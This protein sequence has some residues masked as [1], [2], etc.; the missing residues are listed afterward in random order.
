MTEVVD[1]QPHNVEIDQQVYTLEL[2]GGSSGAGFSLGFSSGFGPGQVTDIKQINVALVEAPKISVVTVAQQGAQGPQG[3][4]GIQGP[5]G[6]QG[7]TG[8]GSQVLFGVAL[9]DNVTQG[10]DGDV[11]FRTNGEVYLKVSGLWDLKMTLAL[12]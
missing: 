12:A 10:I 4:Q 1:T 5:P 7:E 9:P 6:A 3:L 2:M 8:V 11:Y